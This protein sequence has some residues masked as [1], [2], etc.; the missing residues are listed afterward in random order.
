MKHLVIGGARS[1]KSRYAEAQTSALSSSPFYI[2]TATAEDNEMKHRITR[3]QQ[4]RND[5]AGEFQW[6][7]IE[8]P[9][10][11]AARIDALNDPNAAL[12]IDCM[13]LWLSN[14]MDRG[15]LDTNKKHFLNALE[16]T[17]ANIVIVSNE[18]GSGVVP[19]GKLS[20]D[21]V[22]EAGWLNQDLARLCD[23]VT[24]VIAGLPTQLKP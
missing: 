21:F 6:T 14:C 9:L 19:M 18:V 23:K 8:E 1:G 17:K 15:V 24:L 5:Q 22:D 10:D 13:T 7:T 4:T 3:H 16:K 12:L 2:A 11:L 20:R